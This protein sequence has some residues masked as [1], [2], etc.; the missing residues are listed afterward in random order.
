MALIFRNRITLIWLLLVC[1][2]LVSFDSAHIGRGASLQSIATCAVMIVAF[3]KVRF[4]GLEFMEL[5]HAPVPLRFAFEGWVLLV[6]AA[7][8]TLYWMGLPR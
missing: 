1:A 6:C 5:R 3:L 4:I 2:T 8:L 7:I